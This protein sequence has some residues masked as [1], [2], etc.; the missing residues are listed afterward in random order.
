MFTASLPP[1]DIVIM[2]GLV[3]IILYKYIYI[4]YM[5]YFVGR[6]VSYFARNDLDSKYK[7]LCNCCTVLIRKFPPAKITCYTVCAISMYEIDTM[8]CSVPTTHTTKMMATDA[9]VLNTATTTTTTT[10]AAMTATVAA[11]TPVKEG[12]R[13]TTMIIV[14]VLLIGL[15]LLALIAF[16]LW[17]VIHY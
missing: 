12:D 13:S 1:P 17:Y 3:D 9:V 8:C 6:C 11:T 7:E 2:Y 15:L 10:A 14:T 16:F 4:F 5:I